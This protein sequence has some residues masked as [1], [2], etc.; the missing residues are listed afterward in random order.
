MN[1]RLRRHVE[2]VATIV[3]ISGLVG[4]G[5]ALAQSRVS[6]EL[7]V[8]SVLHGV[9]IGFWLTMFEI[10]IDRDPRRAGW[11]GCRSPAR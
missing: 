5:Y 4:V 8:T 3:G 11:P 10:G 2:T 1:P 9:G 6:F 7:I